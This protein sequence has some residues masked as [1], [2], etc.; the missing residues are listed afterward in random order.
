LSSKIVGV[1][2]N[3]SYSAINQ[4]I[5]I[6]SI[7]IDSSDYVRLELANVIAT[8]SGYASNTTGY[9][10]NVTVTSTEGL[11]V[12]MPVRGIGISNVT[13]ITDIIGANIT[14][15]PSITTLGAN[16]TCVPQLNYNDTVYV[17]NGFTHG[18]TN[19]YYDPSIKTDKLVPNFSEIPQKIRTTGTIFDGDG[20]KF[21][22]Y[23]VNYVI[24]GQGEQ[25][26]RFPRLNVFD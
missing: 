19:I 25:A 26:V 6:W 21:Y 24:P 17:R 23:R 5:G 2:G 7:N 20:T 8:I 11:F 18:S 3:V 22:D 1:G 16:I 15:Y 10:S 4:R 9:G 14:I 13:V 12:G